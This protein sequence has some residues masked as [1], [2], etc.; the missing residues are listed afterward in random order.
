VTRPAEN[1]QTVEAALDYLERITLSLGPGERTERLNAARTALRDLVAQAAEDKATIAYLVGRM[2]WATGE[3][4]ISSDAIV[5]EACGGVPVGEGG[6]FG[7]LPHDEG[8]LARCELAYERA[9]AHLRPKML[10]LLENARAALA[11]LD[12]AR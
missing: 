10:P 6:P 1:Q 7:E 9:P 2:V 4:G 8:D 11:R 3:T 5:R 12:G